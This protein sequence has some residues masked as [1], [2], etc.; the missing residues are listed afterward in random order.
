MKYKLL[1]NETRVHT[2]ITLYRIQSVSNFSDVK[3]G[4]KGGW[5]EKESNLSQDGNAWI[6]GDATVYDK[7]RV[8]GNAEVYNDAKVY[9]NAEVY[10]YAKVYGN[11]EVFST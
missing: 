9:G 7:A 2:G 4:D 10:D 6:Y 11:A 1:T 3:S 8:Y 5:I